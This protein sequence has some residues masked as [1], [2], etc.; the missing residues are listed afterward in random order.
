ML[1]LKSYE[2]DRL[3]LK[4]LTKESAPMVLS[5]FEENKALFEPWEPMKSDKF[6]TLSYIRTFLTAEYNQFTEGKLIR[7]WV[8][9]KDNPDKIIGTV[10]FQNMI[11]EPYHSC[12]LGYK[13]DGQYHHQG[14]ATESVNKCID[15][16]FREYHIHRINAYIMPNNTASLRLINRLSFRYEGTAVSFARICGEWT[17]HLHYVL[18]NPLD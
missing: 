8:Y 2:T 9:K 11:R 10:C 15:I 7:F 3:R 13:F 14:F 6:Y 16:M 1:M 12:I 18:V 17:D 4:L 5:F